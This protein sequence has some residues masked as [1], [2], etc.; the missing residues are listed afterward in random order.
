MFSHERGFADAPFLLDLTHADPSAQVEWSADGSPPDT[1]WTGPVTIDASRVVR[2]RATRPGYRPSAVVTHTWIFL[3]Q[4][5]TSAGMNPSYAADPQYGPRMRQGLEDL[6][7]MCVSVD[8]LPDDWNERPA[9]V[10]V[11]LPDGVRARSCPWYRL[12]ASLGCRQ[13]AKDL[14]RRKRSGLNC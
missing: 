11:F 4:V 8:T 5:P 9:S 14:G 10:E 2:A 12:T 6:P 3:D 1:A 13:T 7:T